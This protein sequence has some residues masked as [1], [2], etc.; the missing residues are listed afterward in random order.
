MYIS[1][2]VSFGATLNRIG[3]N[4]IDIAKLMAKIYDREN[5]NNH[6]TKT[7]TY[8][9][10][11]IGNFKPNEHIDISFVDK[12]GCDAGDSMHSRIHKAKLG[13]K[14]I[15]EHLGDEYEFF[16]DF[17]QAIRTDTLISRDLD[18]KEIE[19]F[20]RQNFTPSGKAKF[21]YDVYISGAS[22]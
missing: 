8:S 10:V 2:S 17:A 11:I 1:N 7:L 6:C 14:I 4:A 18:E 9:L 15:Y 21:V 20:K 19:E 13:N 3:K 12:Y 5:K 16:R 22:S